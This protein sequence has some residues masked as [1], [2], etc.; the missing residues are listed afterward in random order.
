MLTSA[1]D[2]KQTLTKLSHRAD[3][4]SI[5]S[6]AYGRGE[7]VRMGQFRNLT[8][9]FKWYIRSK[10][11]RLRTSWSGVR[12]S[13]GAP[14]PLHSMDSIYYHL[15]QRTGLNQEILVIFSYSLRLVFGVPIRL[16]EFKCLA[17]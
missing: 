16:V 4:D 13:P 9:C 8:C 2:R 15:S 10:D 12:I 1:L 17:I 7:L 6:I 5:K 14:F 11:N 3:T